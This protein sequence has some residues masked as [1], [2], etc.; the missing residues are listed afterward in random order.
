[1]S[2]LEAPW[3]CVSRSLWRRCGWNLTL[4]LA[5]RVRSWQA[6]RQPQ[7]EDAPG[8]A[9]AAKRRKVRASDFGLTAT[10]RSTYRP[11]CQEQSLE[12]RMARTSETVLPAV[13]F[14]FLFGKWV[15]WPAESGVCSLLVLSGTRFEQP[16]CS[17]FWRRT[18]G[19]A[20]WGCRQ[21][22]E[23]GKTKQARQA[24]QKV[25]KGKCCTSMPGEGHGARAWKC[26]DICQ[27]L[28]GAGPHRTGGSTCAH[29]VGGTLTKTHVPGPLFVELHR[30]G[31]S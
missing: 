19:R 18:C 20:R 4:A 11:L 14:R 2:S 31:N 7:E 3:L 6:G 15:G 24:L 12:E 21:G 27:Q 26:P 30:S 22:H 29:M 1:M 25:R 16:E 8:E 5:G 10:P 13:F 23:T 28:V 17:V 9:V